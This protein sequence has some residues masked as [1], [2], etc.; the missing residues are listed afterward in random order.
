M[1]DYISQ[2]EFEALLDEADL[3]PRPVF[4]QP[5]MTDRGYFT[6]RESVMKYRQGQAKLIRE[7][8]GLEREQKKFFKQAERVGSTLDRLEKAK[9]DGIAAASE[10]GNAYDAS[11]IDGQI[12]EAEAERDALEEQ[13]EVIARK[14]E[15]ISE[16]TAK[17]GDLQVD[18]I[19]PY[20]RAIMYPQADGTAKYWARPKDIHGAGEF[21]EA[22]RALLRDAPGN[23]FER[24]LDAITGAGDASRAVPPKS[25]S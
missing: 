1:P 5:K 19:L 7:A 17:F 14:L 23:E 13:V 16:E 8:Q 20:I 3:S 9:A 18:L 2:E 12:A 11:A 15:A 6:R 25:G 4:V 22:A 24:M 10:V 21:E